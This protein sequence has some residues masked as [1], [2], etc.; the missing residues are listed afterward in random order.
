L[1]QKSSGL[2]DL[3]IYDLLSEIQAHLFEIIDNNENILDNRG[4]FEAE[5]SKLLADICAKKPS[6]VQLIDMD[7][8]EL[9]I[10]YQYFLE[11]E[12]S[13]A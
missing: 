5:I 12:R 4:Y 8:L 1:K 13:V 2:D 9:E 3:G 7:N 10:A 11:L 6:Y